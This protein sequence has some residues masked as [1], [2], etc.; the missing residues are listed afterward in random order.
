M[1][2]IIQTKNIGPVLISSHVIKYFIEY[3][4][5]EDITDAF[6]RIIDILQSSEIEQL[7]IPMYSSNL[8]FWCIARVQ[9]FSP[10]YQKK[11]IRLFPWY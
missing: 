1:K 8:E 7:S 3:F 9:W 11:I 4:S 5:D 2:S 6:K 10:R